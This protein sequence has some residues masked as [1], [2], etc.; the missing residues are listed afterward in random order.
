MKLILFKPHHEPIWFSGEAYRQKGTLGKIRIRTKFV[1]HFLE[2]IN[3]P[4]LRDQHLIV[5]RLDD[6]YQIDFPKQIAQINTPQ[7]EPYELKWLEE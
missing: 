1:K 7:G 5:R 3:S 2:L 4:I 6:Y